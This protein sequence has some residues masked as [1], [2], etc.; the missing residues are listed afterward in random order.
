MCFSASAS[1]AAGTLLLGLGTGTWRAVRRPCERPFAAIPLLF[2]TQQFI[3][4]VIWLTFGHEATVLNTVMT[5]AY[6]VFSHLLWP[7]FVPLAV[8]LIEPPGWRRRALAACVAAGAVVSA[9]LLFTIA[10]GGIVSQATGHHIEYVT[11]HYFALA[12]MALYLLSTSASQL[13][14]THGAVRAFGLLALLSFGAAYVAYTTWFISVWCYFAAALSAVVLL[15][16]V[17]TPVRLER[18]RA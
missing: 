4:G 5:Y 11:P 8:L 6:A 17:A 10:D 16:F 14:S 2:A 1:F 13:L 3:E 9:S 12:T 7:V 15:H 18:S